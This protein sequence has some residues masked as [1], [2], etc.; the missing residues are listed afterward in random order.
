[1]VFDTMSAR[2]PLGRGDHVPPVA[3]TEI[4]DVIIPRDV[5]HIEHLLHHHIRVG[6]PDDV[7]T[8][9]SGFRRVF[10][11]CG[12]S[13]SCRNDAQREQEYWKGMNLNLQTGPEDRS[14]EDY[15]A[16]EAPAR[17]RVDGGGHRPARMNPSFPQF[18]LIPR[19]P[20]E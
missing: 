12:L 14:V 3:R 11:R 17:I 18:Q 1:I 19:P 6:H 7:F 2:A 20:D 10:T 15:G 16:Y 9:L 4:D 8:G 5:R 13:E